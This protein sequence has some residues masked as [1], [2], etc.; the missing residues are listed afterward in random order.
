MLCSISGYAQLSVDTTTVK[1]EEEV[2]PIATDRPDQTECPFIVPKG[3]MQIETGT[4]IEVDK[5]Q[6]DLVDKN[7]TYNTT[8]FKYGVNEHFELRLISEF[9]GTRSRIASSDSMVAR[10]AGLNSFAVG[11]KIFLCEQKGIIPKTSLI[12]HLQLPYFGSQDNRPH[13]LAPRFR[14]LMQ[15]TISNRF[16]LSYNLGAEWDGNTTTATAIYTLSL[17]I[18]LVD[19]LSMFV[20]TYGFMAENASN[21]DVFNGT[22]A[23]DHRFDA[24]FTYLLR[25]NLQLDTSAGIG[26]SKGS[27]DGF[28]SCGLSWRFKV[29]KDK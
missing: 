1:K 15:H 8:L 10:S 6:D 14:F 2:A 5:S 9:I 21:Q 4:Q 22:F 3:H 25:N 16:S 20:E 11:T 17:G 19:R 23:N 27:P 28:V 29:A 26:L 12:C 13:H 18:A 24:G 7:L